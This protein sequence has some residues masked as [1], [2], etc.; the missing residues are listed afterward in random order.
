MSTQLEVRPQKS[1]FFRRHE[2]LTLCLVNLFFLL[3][4]LAAGEIVTRH[5]THYEI[6]YYTAPP[7][8]NGLNHY[9]WGSVPI[10]SL[11]FADEEFNLNGTK[12]RVGWFGDS[13]N[14]G[15]GAGYPYRISD[16]IR[17]QF[18]NLDNWNTGGRFGSEFEAADWEKAATDLHL[19]TVVYVMNLNDILPA[20]ESESAS[21]QAVYRLSTFTRGYLDVLRDKSYLYNYLRMTIKNAMQRLGFEASG[22]YAYELWP[23]Q[24]DHVFKYFAGRVNETFHHLRQK[25][26]QMCVL[27]SPYEMQVSDDAARTYAKLGFKWEDGFLQGSAQKKVM[28]YL[29]KDL[30]VYDGLDAFP[31]H[32]AKVGS[33]FVYNE[34]DKIDWN[35]PN[36]AGHAALAKGF[37]ESKSCPFLKQADA[38]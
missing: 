32:D 29:D 37:S 2:R 5:L 3:L 13:V 6:G 14:G 12:P 1:N 35:H 27:I 15:L 16:L 20:L 30:P 10:N 11:G 7:T 38:R 31:N 34:G 17:Q 8:K 22:Y 24:A 4:L 19:N 9:P 26:V 18:P 21:G 23:D 28:Q 25:G 36:R 33:L